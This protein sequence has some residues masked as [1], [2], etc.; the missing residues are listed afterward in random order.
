M[1]IT[2]GGKIGSGKSS[3]AKRIAKELNLKHYSTGDFF[4]EFAQRQ[5]MDVTEFS[6]DV[7]EDIDNEIDEKTK[8]I[9]QEEDN[10][11]FDSRLAF[12]FI[13]N[14]IKIFLEVSDEEGAKRIFS[15]QRESEDKVNDLSILIEKNK[16]RWALSRDRFLKIYKVDMTDTN[17][18]DIVIDTTE[19]NID[20]VVE[21]TK[22]AIRALQ[23]KKKGN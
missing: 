19:L 4:R 2:I 20:E 18:Y 21:E 10:F 16:K 15:N 5:G 22:R 11:I 14:A 23:K 17:E 7:T 1:K 9:G 13:P 8:K 12:H 3:I 6:K